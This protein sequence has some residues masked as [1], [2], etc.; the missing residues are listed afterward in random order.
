[1]MGAE[2][3]ELVRVYLD[4]T[5]GKIA[6]LRQAADAGSMEGLVAPAHSLK[7]T[8]ANLGALGLSDMAKRIEHGA[9]QQKL[10]GAPQQLVADVVAEFERVAG[11]LRRYLQ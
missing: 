5:P 8:S 2:F 11:E 6:Q 3:T 4:E 9:R 10:P 7:S 1:M